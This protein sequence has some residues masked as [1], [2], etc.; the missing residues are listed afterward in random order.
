MIKV[1]HE[2]ADEYDVFFIHKLFIINN[3]D[4]YPRDVY[5]KPG[6]KDIPN[7]I[8]IYLGGEK[9]RWVDSL[10]HLGNAVTPNLIHDIHSVEK[11]YLFFVY[12]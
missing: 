3:L 4:V 2:F 1:C 8:E 12:L 5:T 9:I 11:V 6:Y 10:K 7:A